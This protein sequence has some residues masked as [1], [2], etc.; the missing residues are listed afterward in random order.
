[1]VRQK[2]MTVSAACSQPEASITSC[3]VCGSITGCTPRNVAVSRTPS[4]S[5]TMS[6]SP[7]ATITGGQWSSHAAHPSVPALKDGRLRV[8]SAKSSPQRESALNRSTYST[9]SSAGSWLSKKSA[10]ASSAD[11]AAVLSASPRVT[12]H[13]VRSER[14]ISRPV[15][16]TFPEGGTE[17]SNAAPLAVPDTSKYLSTLA[18]PNEWPTRTGG[19]T[20]CT[21]SVSS[22]KARRSS[23]CCEMRIF[24]APSRVGEP[25]APRSDTAWQVQPRAAENLG[26]H[27]SDQHQAP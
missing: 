5:T 19:A 6:A 4:S 16:G 25:E 10:R 26:I 3:A 1:M 15:I 2:S 22:T 7:P 21:Q 11:R 17:Q 14:R 23:T 8:K 24:V 12:S 9:N 13:E 18:P 27:F 20:P